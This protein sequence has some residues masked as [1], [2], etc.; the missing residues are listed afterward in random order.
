MKL[1]INDIVVA[2]H[3]LQVNEGDEGERTSCLKAAEFLRRELVKRDKASDQRVA[4]R[5]HAS[6]ESVDE[7]LTEYKRGKYYPA[8]QTPL[9]ID[10][11]E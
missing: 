5:F 3:W 10:G 2:I 9:F 11:E 6:V 4:N 7:R 8:W 1:E